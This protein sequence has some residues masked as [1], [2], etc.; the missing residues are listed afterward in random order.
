MLS[1]HPF[2]SSCL[3]PCDTLAASSLVKGGEIV[4]AERGRRGE[5]KGENEGE[6]D[7]RCKLNGVYE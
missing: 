6:G 7:R 5:G 1:V 2:V 4:G 3:R